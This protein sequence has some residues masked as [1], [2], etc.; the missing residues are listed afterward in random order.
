MCAPAQA[1]SHSNLYIKPLTQRAL[2]PLAVRDIRGAQLGHLITVRGITT[3]VS[4]VKPHIQVNAYSCESCGEESFQEIL[5]RSFLP[6]AEC[7]TADC[8]INGV[9]GS[10]QMQTRA[11]KFL[12]FQEMKIQEMVSSTSKRGRRQYTSATDGCPDSAHSHPGR[13]S[14]RRSYPPHHDDPSL[15]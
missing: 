1:T 9:R 3:R 5:S 10:L 13:P 12:P 7:P 14:S 15:R 11:S 6:L 2:E 8:R 4:D